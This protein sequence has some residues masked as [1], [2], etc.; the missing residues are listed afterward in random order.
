MPTDFIPTESELAAARAVIERAL[1][2]DLAEIGDLTSQLLLPEG[3]SGAFRFVARQPGVVAGLPF[4]RIVFEQLDP[5]VEMMVLVGDGT[6]VSPGTEIARVSGP[7]RS[8]LGGERTALNLLTMLGG[9]ATLTRRFVDAVQ[10][11]RAAI[12]D[13]RKTFPGLRAL[14]K[15][16]VRCGGG[17]NHR[18]GLYD[19]VLI[20]DNHLAAW[21]EAGGTLLATLLEQVRAKS[22]P[23]VP[24]EIEVDTLEQFQQALAGRPD[25][26]L[27][28]N[29]S[30]EEL[31]RAVDLRN[32][33]APAV[34][35]EASGRVS[36]ST[37]RAIAETG[38]DRISV[39]AL[40]HSAPALDIGCDWS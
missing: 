4:A 23:G 16:A 37:V 6:P 29:M 39:G 9:T 25:I 30:P 11:T 8:L 10:G 12:L 33:L 14:Q 5:T 40:T 27:C 28:D 15:Y 7:A 24:I 38:I 18:M 2:E 19:G 32:A 20:K 31:R 26:I 1:Q 17:T 22:P 34:N 3:R 35:L 21:K 36:L 13:T